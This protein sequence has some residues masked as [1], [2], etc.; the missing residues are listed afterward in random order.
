V[1]RL[2]GG[3]SLSICAQDGKGH[4]ASYHID[5]SNTPLH[6]KETDSQAQDD[7]KD[8]IIEKGFMRATRPSTAQL[9]SNCWLQ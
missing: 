3:Q 6:F 1:G 9:S 2:G 5:C 4:N 7:T 8:K